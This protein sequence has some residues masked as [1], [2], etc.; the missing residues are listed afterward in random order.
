MGW[1]CTGLGVGVLVPVLGLVLALG[2]P[3]KP[4]TALGTAGW[5][6]GSG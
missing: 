3:E 2:P 5:G 1:G 6:K 4:A